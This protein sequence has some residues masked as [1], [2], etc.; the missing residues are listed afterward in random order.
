MERL[1]YRLATVVV[2]LP[3]LRERSEDIPML[4]SCFL[5]RAARQQQRTIKGF[6]STAMDVLR[7][8]RWPGNIRELQNVIER[9]VLLCTSDVIRP[10]YLS[11][12]ASQPP[13]PLRHVLRDEKRR[14]IEQALQQTGGNQAAA[15]R[16]L[17]LTPSN[18]A[19]FMKNVGARLPNAVQ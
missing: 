19:R 8:Y 5:E 13:P 4:A 2:E 10:E 16:L 18:L 1:P 14:R 12:I 17:G 3:P 15:A 6:S 7:A 9:A 11:D